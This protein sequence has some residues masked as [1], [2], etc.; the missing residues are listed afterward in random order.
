L[1]CFQTPEDEK[2]KAFVI[3]I[4]RAFQNAQIVKWTL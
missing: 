3:F 4:Q 2:P 1:V